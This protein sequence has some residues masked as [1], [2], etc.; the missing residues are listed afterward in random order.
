MFGSSDST[1]P[2]NHRL[3]LVFALRNSIVSRIALLCCWIYERT[4]AEKTPASMLSQCFASPP[5]LSATFN[6]FHITPTVQCFGAQ[7][8]SLHS[9]VKCVSRLMKATPGEQKNY[10]F[11]FVIRKTSERDSRENH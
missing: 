1:S 4:T 9:R 3:A 7:Q 2:C 5:P 6:H 8:F 11:D 10:S